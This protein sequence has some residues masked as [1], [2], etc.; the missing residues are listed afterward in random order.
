MDVFVFLSVGIATGFLTGV[1]FHK[2]VISEAVGIK[3]HVTAEIAEVRADV[4][5]LLEK[6]SGKVQEVSAKL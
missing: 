6:V 5:D 2:F 4:A 3:E 1:L